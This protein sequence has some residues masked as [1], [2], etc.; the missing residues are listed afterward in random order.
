MKNKIVVMFG[1]AASLAASGVSLAQQADMQLDEVIVTAERR[2]ENLQ[3]TP[4]AVS[5][6]GSEDLD[7]LQI[8]SIADLDTSVPS[9]TVETNVASN[10]SITIAMRGNAEQNAAILFSE[11]GVGL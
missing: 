2:A 10:A 8:G 3:T 5:A 7:R 11:P 9:L 4:I 1:A 6:L